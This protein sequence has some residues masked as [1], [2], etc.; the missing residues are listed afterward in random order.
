MERMRGAAFGDAIATG[1]FT[2]IG[3]GVL[4]IGVDVALDRGAGVATGTYKTGLL[5]GEGCAVTA[6]TGF[7]AEAP[8]AATC[9]YHSSAI[10]TASKRNATVTAANLPMALSL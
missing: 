4:G 9:A 3:A 8:G 7:G 6:C 10:T 2:A 1:C 5:D